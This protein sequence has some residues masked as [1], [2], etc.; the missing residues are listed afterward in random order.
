M[1]QEM[2]STPIVLFVCIHNAGRSQMAEAFLNHLAEGRARAIS[3]GTSPSPSINQTVVEAMR[4]VG[5]DIT[6]KTPKKLTPEM[7]E[8]ASVTITMGC[9]DEESCPTGFARAE[10]WHLTDPQD[11]P[12]EK[13]RLIR[14][15]VKR[16]VEGLLKDLGL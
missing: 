3:A 1:P 11:E 13:V 8:K 4:E 6:G 15:E 16:R 14:D 5:I 10:D 9:R 12:L 2:D 7:I